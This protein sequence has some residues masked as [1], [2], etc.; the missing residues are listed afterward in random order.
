[1]LQTNAQKSFGVKVGYNNSDGKYQPN[2]IIHK[3]ISGIQF[4]GFGQVNLNKFLLLQSNLLF[5]Q[6]GNYG[7]NSSISVDYYERTTFRMSFIELD[8]SIAFQTKI[9]E[10]TKIN[11]GFGPYLGLGLFGK[12]KG[13]VYNF[14]NT[15][16]IKRRIKF[17]NTYAGYEFSTFD[18]FDFG[19]NFN[20]SLAHKKYLF[21]L[22]FS[23]G[24]N[25][26]VPYN[27]MNRTSKNQVLSI[28]AGYYIK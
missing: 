13:M 9:A 4:G 12:D 10:N 11:F 22:N 24:I 17:S 14:G 7:D 28:G 2:D 23:N 16:T 21:Y 3:S 25:S 20:A 18:P 5:T 1:M 15:G 6:K 27:G 8:A 19:L 26:R